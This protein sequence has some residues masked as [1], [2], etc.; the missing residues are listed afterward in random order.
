MALIGQRIGSYSPA[1]YHRISQI[2]IVTNDSI[3]IEVCS[4]WNK[5]AREAEKEWIKDPNYHFNMGQHVAEY[6]GYSTEYYNDF[7]IH[8][9]YKYIKSLDE[10]S[11][12]SDI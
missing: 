7:N 5:E 9:A 2:N 1:S 4:Y 10:Y 3:Q 12:C 11:D 6:I 8:D